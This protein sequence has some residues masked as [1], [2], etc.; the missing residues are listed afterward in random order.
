V[1]WAARLTVFRQTVYRA[2]A[3]GFDRPHERLRA[4]GRSGIDVLADL[5]L[6]EHSVAPWIVEYLHQLRSADL[7]EMEECRMAMFEVG[8]GTH[9][10]PPLESAWRARSSDPNAAAILQAELEG[11]Y[12]R[13]GLSL[14]RQ[15]TY[16][17]D[18]VVVQ[19][20]VMSLLCGREATQHTTAVRAA[21][22]R[23]HQL[24]LLKEHLSIWIPAFTRHLERVADLPLYVALARAARAFV[25]YDRDLLDLL[26][27]DP[28]HHP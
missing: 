25:I 8:S 13:I 12:R 14:T 10:C 18:H 22:S 20:E 19:L 23:D 1:S 27:A 6:Y 21:P 7:M 3:A 24:W 28:S 17:P 16:T 15:D 4:D 26:E 9:A 2:L 5:G 11:F